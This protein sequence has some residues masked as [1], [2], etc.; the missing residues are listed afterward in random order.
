MAPTLVGTVHL[1][2]FP[3]KIHIQKPQSPVYGIGRWSL[4]EVIRH[5][6]GALMNEVSAFVRGD[7]RDMI[8]FSNGREYK[9]VVC[10]K[11]V[12]EPSPDTASVSTLVLEFLAFTTTNKKFLLL[13]LPSL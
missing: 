11:L 8:S 3:R 4:W 2:I 10:H 13:K 12:R 5:E 9:Q 1:G 6:G 7:M